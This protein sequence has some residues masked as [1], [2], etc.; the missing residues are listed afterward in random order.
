MGTE[1]ADA[2][3]SNN[4]GPTVGGITGRGVIGNFRFLELK[5]SYQLLDIL[6]RKVFR[7][8]DQCDI[9]SLDSNHSCSTNYDAITIRV[10]ATRELIPEI[11]ISLVREELE[12]SNR[13]VGYKYG[14]KLIIT[15]DESVE[16]CV[17][18]V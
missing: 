14:E 13:I 1:F 17:W 15:S 2:R 3:D 12:D 8:F 9:G 7:L 18:E 4:F 11:A 16:L 5:K 6:Q 10:A